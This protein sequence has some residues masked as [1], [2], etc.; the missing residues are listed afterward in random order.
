MDKYQIAYACKSGISQ[1]VEI[2]VRLLD[3]DSND[4]QLKEIINHYLNGI[5][6][7]IEHIVT[8]YD[9]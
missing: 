3:P 2:S 7:E 4:R 9:I 6:K 5:K 8:Q 1:F